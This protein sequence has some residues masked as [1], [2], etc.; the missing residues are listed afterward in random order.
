MELT[1]QTRDIEPVLG[2]FWT[3]VVEDWSSLDQHWFNV[4]CL[5]GNVCLVVMLRV[6]FFCP[7]DQPNPLPAKLSNLNFHPL[8][9]LSRSRNAR[10]RGRGP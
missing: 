1:Q 4:S 10:L 7:L 2:Q 8:E 3:D 9:V 5:L 6:L